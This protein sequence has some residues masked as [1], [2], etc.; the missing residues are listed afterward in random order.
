MVYLLSFGKNKT[1]GL[2]NI[3]WMS[4]LI[5]HVSYIKLYYHW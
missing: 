5:I 2:E 1:L 3:F 4:F